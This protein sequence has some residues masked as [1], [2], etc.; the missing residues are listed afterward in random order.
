MIIPCTHIAECR[1]TWA[2]SVLPVLMRIGPHHPHAHSRL[3]TL[4][5]SVD[6]AVYRCLHILPTVTLFGLAALDL[7]AWSKVPSPRM[8]SYTAISSITSMEGNNE[9]VHE[10][11]MNT[12]RSDPLAPNTSVG[13]KNRIQNGTAWMG[14]ANRK[15]KTP[16]QDCQERTAKTGLQAQD[17]Q[18]RAASTVLPA[19]CCQHSAASTEL[20]R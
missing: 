13:N 9:G 12:S 15:N 2:T 4:P 1:P 11:Y 5:S 3:T 20:L 18:N 6:G 17:N 8:C 14:R 16:G 7:G 19:Q 10:Y